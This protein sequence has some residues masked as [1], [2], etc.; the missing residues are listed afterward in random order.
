MVVERFAVEGAVRA[1]GERLSEDERSALAGYAA[2]ATWP[3]GFTVYD[4]GSPADGVFVVLRGRIILRNRI[5]GGRGFVPVVAMPG[6]TFGGEGLADN[7]VYATDARAEDDAATLHLGRARVRALVRERPQ[8]AMALFGQM[9][10][11]HA[12]LLE[13]TRE[14]VT[15]SVEQR[16]VSAILRAAETRADAEA[17]Q[18]LTFDAGEY[19]L[20]CEMVGATR[21]SVSLVVARLSASGLAKRSGGA[22]TVVAPERLADQLGGEPPEER[23]QSVPVAT[24]EARPA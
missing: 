13:R 12:A 16:L 5:K 18:P 20:L 21:E 2:K 3:A 8:L 6:E 23:E 1:A 24:E 10:A 15:Q 9:A 17:G 11:E 14:L 19:R 4:G 22:V 7:G